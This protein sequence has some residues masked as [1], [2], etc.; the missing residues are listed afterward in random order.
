MDE[1][2]NCIRGALHHPFLTTTFILLYILSS[3]YTLTQL[4]QI[5]IE[6]STHTLAQALPALPVC[7]NYRS[8]PFLCGALLATHTALPKCDLA[9]FWKRK[10]LT[11][12]PL[13]PMCLHR[14][15]SYAEYGLSTVNTPHSFWKRFTRLSELDVSRF[16]LQWVLFFFFPNLCSAMDSFLVWHS[17]RENIHLQ[18]WHLIPSLGR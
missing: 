3:A 11:F 9:A 12:F 6:M 1:S 2:Q 10:H 14:I 18:D 13:L 16:A 4:P 15:L 7:W 17:I 5:L 8:V